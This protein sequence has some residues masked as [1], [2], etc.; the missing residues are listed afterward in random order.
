MGFKTLVISLRKDKTWLDEN[1]L[2]S[3]DEG[4][5]R[6]TDLQRYLQSR[7][8]QPHLLQLH[9]R[10]WRRSTALPSFCHSQIVGPNTLAHCVDGRTGRVNCHSRDL[11]Q[12]RWP[13]VSVGFISGL[14]LS[15]R[16]RWR[17]S[18]A[19]RNPVTPYCIALANSTRAKRVF[20][21]EC[22]AF[23]L[24]SKHCSLNM[25]ICLHTWDR[26]SGREEGQTSPVERR[27]DHSRG[28]VWLTP[29]EQRRGWWWWWGGE[30]VTWLV[31]K[32]GGS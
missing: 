2:C 20:F 31:V 28:K 1:A 22:A 32:N 7:I 13:T 9:R 27:A 14:L 26:W 16:I 10:E 6:A 12:L 21:S 8:L 29:W 25:C 4:V 23:H 3:R 18:L 30:M 5:E 11:E 19:T 24:N 17:T 15:G